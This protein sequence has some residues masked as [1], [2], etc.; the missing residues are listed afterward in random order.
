V[1]ADAGSIP[2]ISTNNKGHLFF[3]WPFLLVE[4][5]WMRTQVPGSKNLSGTNFNVRFMHGPEGVSLK[6][7]TNIPASFKQT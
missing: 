2:A 4:M 6:D 5:V 3:R 7:E 1:L